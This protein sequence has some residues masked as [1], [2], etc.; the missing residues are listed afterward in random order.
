MDNNEILR[1]LAG[2]LTLS[3]DRLAAIFALIFL[4]SFPEERSIPG[5]EGGTE[6]LKEMGIVSSSQRMIEVAELARRYASSHATVLLTGE[7]G[8]GKEVLS[9]AIHSL[10]RRSAMPFVAVNCGALPEGLA[11]SELFGHEKGAFTGADRRKTGLFEAAM[12][13]Y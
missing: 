5:V 1:R 13:V 7:T 11:E 8:T 3:E 9:R 12:A 10:S 2:G 6:L 4:P